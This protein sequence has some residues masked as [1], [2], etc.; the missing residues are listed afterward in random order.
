MKGKELEKPL[1][2]DQLEAAIRRTS[3]HHPS[4]A[5]MLSDL[6]KF[7]SGYR[8]QRSLDYYFKFLDEQK[9]CI[10]RDLRLPYKDIFF[11]IDVAI[12]STFFISLLEVKNNKGTLEFDLDF[13]QMIQKYLES[14]QEIEKTYSDPIQQVQLH[15]FQLNSWIE[16]K[17][18]NPIPI[19]GNVVISNSSTRILPAKPQHRTFLIDKVIRPSNI[20]L[21]LNAFQNKYQRPI[22]TEKELIKLSKQLINAHTP[23]VTDILAEYEISSNEIVK[24][25]QCPQCSNLPMV[26]VYGKWHCSVCMHYSKSAHLYA[27]KDHYL[28]Y[29]PLMKNCQMRDFLNISSATVTSNL[30]SALNF[31]YTGTTRSRIYIVDLKHLPL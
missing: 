20:Q 21:K 23:K 1:I 11:Q 12:L 13:N 26:R 9:L 10:I 30:L 14:G 5:K 2:I 16:N 27:V 4:R 28:L 25:V 31:P 29:G 24:G 18:Y 7:R 19:L 8:G 22:L 3:I 6:A 17:K 15:C